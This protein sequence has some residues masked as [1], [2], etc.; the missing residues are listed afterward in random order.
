MI[1][2]P[3]SRC[4]IHRED[5][6]KAFVGDVVSELP[7]IVSYPL[8]S[9]PR[10]FPTLLGG[11]QHFIGHLFGARVRFASF[12]VAISI[13][14]LLSPWAYPQPAAAISDRCAIYHSRLSVP[15][16]SAAVIGAPAAPLEAAAA[17]AQLLYSMPSF[18]EH[19]FAHHHVQALPVTSDHELLLDVTA[20]PEVYFSLFPAEYQRGSA[21]VRRFLSENLY[22]PVGNVSFTGRIHENLDVIPAVCDNNRRSV[23]PF[24][25]FFFFRKLRFLH[26]RET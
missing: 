26:S 11:R 24:Q 8:P 12:E 13:A 9:E 7:G 4:R 3:F 16:S 22:Q 15:I 10:F 1:A 6:L 17:L 14:N 19:Q 21:R 2:T 18:V 5:R 20:P 25:F 23:S